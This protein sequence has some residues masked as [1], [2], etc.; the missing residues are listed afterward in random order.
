AGDRRGDRG[1]A[2]RAPSER[3][4]P[5]R[6]RGQVVRGDRRDHGMQSGYRKIAAEKGK[7]LVRGNH[8]SICRLGSGGSGTGAF[9]VGTCYRTLNLSPWIV[10]SFVISTSR[11]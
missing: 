11:S 7:K 8:C 4:H 2:A 5:P 10:A 1:E 6:A 9:L 3:V